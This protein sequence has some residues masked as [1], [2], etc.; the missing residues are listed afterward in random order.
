MKHDQV[1]FV[2]KFHDYCHIITS[3]PYLFIEQIV[4][5]IWGQLTE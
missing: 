5:R 3:I 1:F 2:N 4:D